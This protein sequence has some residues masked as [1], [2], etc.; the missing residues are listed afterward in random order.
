MI[1]S[2]LLKREEAKSLYDGNKIEF[3]ENSEAMALVDSG[4][5][6]CYCLFYIENGKITIEK[7]SP[8]ADIML[9]DGALRS[10]LFIAANRGIMEAER[11]ETVSGALIKRLGFSDNEENTF[12]DITN[13]FS[14]CENCKKD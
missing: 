6:L 5:M 14:S 7:L 10:A 8:E 4:E 2:K 9:C 3:K 12:V 11:K 13:L 1:E